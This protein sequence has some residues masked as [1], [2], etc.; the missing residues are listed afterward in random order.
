MPGRYNVIRDF[1]DLADTDHLDFNPYVV[2]AVIRLAQPL[3]FSRVKMASVSKDVSEGALLRAKAPLVITDD[4]LNLQTQDSKRYHVKNMNMVL[5]SSSMNYLNEVL[6]GDWCMAWILNSLTKQQDLISKINQG[7]ACND[8][9][10][11]LKFLGRIHSVRKQIQVDGQ[12]GV[13]TVNYTI[14]SSGFSELDSMLFYDAT[15]ASAPEIDKSIGSWLARLGLQ[16]QDLFGAETK[17]GIK[18][19]NTNVI[20]PTLLDLIVGKGPPSKS[21]AGVSILTPEGETVG[22]L[23]QTL[24]EAPYSY[25]VPLMVG[26]LL[27]LTP[28]E[29]SKASHIVSYA[30][31]LELLQGIQNYSNTNGFGMFIPDLSRTENDRR[32]FTSTELLGTFLPFYP[33]FTN[34]PLFQLL[35]QFS[36]PTVNELFT[37]LRVNP[38]GAIMP[39][40]IFR[41]IPF[42]TDAMP[43][44]RDLPVTK[45]SSLPRWVVPAIMIQSADIGRS[46]ATRTNFVHIY[47]ASSLL[48]NNVPVQYQLINNPPAMDSLDVQRSGL[49][50]YIATVDCWL[51]DQVGKAPRQWINLVADRMIGSQ[52]TLNGTIGSFGIQSPICPGDNLEFDGVVFHIESVSHS[53]SITPDG[54]KSWT[55]RL[56]LTNG[57]RADVSAKFSS[58]VASPFPIYPGFLPNDLTTNDPGLTLEHVETTGGTSSPDGVIDDRQKAPT[59]TQATPLNPNDPTEPP[60]FGGDFDSNPEF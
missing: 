19:N 7:V 12:S 17:T 32:R 49:R 1:G 30:D 41:Q 39:T 27:G 13:K 11:G 50:P 51:D 22:Q 28:S 42:T 52:Y 26:Q 46:D 45:F 6:P 16:I 3:S 43:V 2:V 24:S 37:T 40:L 14:Q 57:M 31:I 33:S 21:Q 35:S 38:E 5:K 56:E 10:S 60:R 34:Q 15:L 8:F 29:A 36:N 23:P 58:D 54:H 55:T 53:F 47:G 20:V 18:K 44:I 25:L 48:Q 59:N 9:S 4:C